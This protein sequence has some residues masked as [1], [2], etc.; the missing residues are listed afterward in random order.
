MNLHAVRAI[1]TS[2]L[3]SHRRFVV[4]SLVSPVLSTALYFIVFAAALGPHFA[5]FNGVGYGEFIVPG[6]IMLSVVTDTIYTAAY[7]IHAPKISGTLYETLSAP[8]S[9]VEIVA[10]HVG[11]AATK[12]VV[13]GTV[14]LLV[15]RLFVDFH[16]IHPLHLMS[17]LLLSSLTCGCLGLTI[18][19]MTETPQRLTL[20]VALIIT[21]LTFL[22]GC[23]YSLQTLPPI[24]RH[25]ALLNPMIYITSGF[26]WSF[27]GVSD[28]DIMVS[29]VVVV[30]ALSISAMVVW[31]IL[32]SG[33]KLRS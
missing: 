29:Y 5:Y 32:Q 18:G 23:F 20:M 33:F 28:L 19:I 6:L 13:L 15:A 4:L 9:A 1:Y 3:D 17:L 26:R 12:A 16:V 22:G 27:Y 31:K 14:T 10:G 25:I 8:I 21:P 2:R 7:S 11:A 30:A 24:W